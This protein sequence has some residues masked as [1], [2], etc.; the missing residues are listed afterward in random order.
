MFFYIY[1][2]TSPIADGI[3]GYDFLTDKI[4]YI[5]F[6]KRIMKIKLLSENK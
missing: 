5:D 2:F 6:D 3:L 4:L 1:N